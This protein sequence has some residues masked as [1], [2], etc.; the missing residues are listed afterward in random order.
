MQR[1]FQFSN[2]RSFCKPSKASLNLRTFV[3]TFSNDA[4]QEVSNQSINYADEIITKWR[5]WETEMTAA[6]ITRTLISSIRLNALAIG[7]QSM[8]IIVG[9]LPQLITSTSLYSRHK[10]S[11]KVRMLKSNLHRLTSFDQWRSYT[12]AS[13]CA[14]THEQ[15]IQ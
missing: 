7:P 10:G 13:E 4:P 6:I 3:I 2:I 12:Y 15:L 14:R 9:F 1:S 8:L 11:V 5:L